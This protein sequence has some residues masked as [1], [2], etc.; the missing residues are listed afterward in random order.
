M[1]RLLIP[2]VLLAT[3]ACATDEELAAYAASVTRGRAVAETQCAGCHAVGTYGESAV[4]AA[5]P[6]RHVLDRYSGQTL[7]TDLSEGIRVAHAMASFHFDAYDSDALVA[8][9]RSIRSDAPEDDP[10][11]RKTP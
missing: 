9:L 3:S 5:P 2:L 8:Y 6:F 7:A 4:R 1:H 11:R 10:E